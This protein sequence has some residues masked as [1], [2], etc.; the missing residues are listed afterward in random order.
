RHN[1]NTRNTWRGKLVFALFQSHRLT[2]DGRT[3]LQRKQANTASGHRSASG[4]SDGRLPDLGAA[5]AHERAS[6]R[7][8]CAFAYRI[9]EGRLVLQANHGMLRPAGPKRRPHGANGLDQAAIHAA[10]NDSVRLMVDFGDFE[11]GDDFIGCSA[12]VADAHDAI[13]AVTTRVQGFSEI[14]VWRW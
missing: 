12:N 8:E 9:E 6:G 14:A 11:F 10:V 1:R 5:A 7:A 2:G 13:P 4:V 3:R